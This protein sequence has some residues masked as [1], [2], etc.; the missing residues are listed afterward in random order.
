MSNIS[1]YNSVVPGTGNLPGQ[2]AT[3]PINLQALAEIVGSGSTADS[4]VLGQEAPQKFAFPPVFDKLPLRDQAALK[5]LPADILKEVLQDVSAN[6]D[7]AKVQLSKRLLDKAREAVGGESVHFEPEELFRVS[8]AAIAFRVLDALTPSDRARIEGM[9]FRRVPASTF[10]ESH[11]NR[12]TDGAAIVEVETGRG[13]LGRLGYRAAKLLEK[14][15]LTAPVGMMLRAWFP[16]ALAEYRNRVIEI[17][18]AQA[19]RMQEVLMHEIGHQVQFGS[20]TDLGSMREWAK[21]SGWRDA[22]GGEAFG[23]DAEGSVRALNPGIRPTRTDNFVY[24]NFTEDLTPKAVAKTLAEIQDPELRQ[25]FEQ[26]LRV[27]RTMRE[28]ISE[29]FGVEAM[30]YSMVNPLEDFAESFRAFYMDPELLLRKAPDKFLYL[31]ANARRYAPAEVGAMLKSASKNPQDV[32]T[33]LAQSGISQ[34]SLERITKANGVVADVAALG[35]QAKTELNAAR[36]QGAS[37]PPLRQAFLQ[38]QQSVAARDLAFVNAFNQS[39]AKAL[40]GVW[41]RLSPAEQAQFLDQRKRVEIVQ[42][43]QGGKMSFASAAEAGYRAIE[44]E[45]VRNFG[46]RLLDDADFRENLKADP[47]AAL[48]PMVKSLPKPL[49]DSLKDPQMRVSLSVF[50]DTLSRLIAYD[51]VPL[52]GGGDL[53]RMFEANLETMDEATL[54]ASIGTLRNDPKRMAEVFSGLGLIEVNGIKVP[55]GG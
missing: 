19:T 6:A 42:K 22:S 41:E 51:K 28:A 21:L 30:G 45:A 54:S 11:F 43:M 47:M 13:A 14:F 31:N 53:H 35:Q 2:R 9:T 3:G 7:A 1:K 55:P 36:K 50:A 48:A 24:E 26:T 32:L 4:V 49:R 34:E 38:I 37:L 29:V 44:V 18:D 33:T 5:A 40:A 8:D 27:K 52:L 46:R 10:D 20:Q 25:E 16:H 39:P 12:Q 23:V 17:G 15:A